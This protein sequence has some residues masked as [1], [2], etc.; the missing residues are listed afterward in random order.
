MAPYREHLEYVLVVVGQHRLHHVPVAVRLEK[1][2]ERMLGTVGVPKAE[3]GVVRESVRLVDLVV[4]AP[5][6]T[7]HVHIDRWIDHRVVEGGVEHLLLGFAALD[8]DLGKL[9]LPG[10]SGFAADLLEGF[11]GGFGFQVLQG[12]GRTR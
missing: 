4:E 2:Q 12:S 7:V 1:G 11:A 10:C 5:V 3:D 9:F 6:G 8:L